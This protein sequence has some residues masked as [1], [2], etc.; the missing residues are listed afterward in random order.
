MKRRLLLLLALCLVAGT[1]W[2]QGV[3]V[4]ILMDF[5]GPLASLSPAIEAGA[6]LA[7]EQANAAGGLFGQKIQTARRDTRANEQVALDAASKLVQVDRVPAIVGALA[8]GASTAA[9]SVT[10]PNQVV[11]ISPA[12]TSPALTSLKDNDFF[13]RTCP[14]DA[15]QGRVQGVLARN[16]GYKTAGVLYVNNPYGKGLDESFTAA[17]EKA[18]G[19]VTAS[20][21]YDQEKPSYRGEVEQAIKGNPDALVVIA[22]PADGNKQ[23]V[24]AIEQGYKGDF[25]FA[26]GM[27]AD[28]VAKGP[29][30]EQVSGSLGTAPGSL[31]TPAGARFEADYRAFVTRTG[32]HVDVTAPYRKE[33][34]DA[35]ASILL[36]IRSVGPGFLKLAPKE[37]GKAIRDHLRRVTGPRGV[38]VGYDEFK[39][40]FAMLGK[41]QRI[42]YE[43]VSGP[44]TF[45]K[46]GDTEEAAFDIW[47]FQ[48]GRVATVWTVQ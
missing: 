14:S 27:K 38:R 11:M 15:L 26:D 25:L 16:L 23:L 46:N 29:A 33:A 19:K 13:F 2:A 30:G 8:S 22:Y 10:I 32:K 44:L 31:D 36:A 20:V 28:S 7:V 1:A 3:K 43:G 48:R 12:S 47:G 21:A 4:G 17:F 42:N 40:A 35:M 34:Y 18:G 45:D 6:L 41:G 5:S 37:Q 9:S 24:S 39:R